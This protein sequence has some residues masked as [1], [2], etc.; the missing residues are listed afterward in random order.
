[1]KATWAVGTLLPRHTRRAKPPSSSSDAHTYFTPSGS[2]GAFCLRLT[3]L[4][5][6]VVVKPTAMAV[7]PVCCRIGR[8]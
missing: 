8:N 6:F 2:V 7:I 5:G 1:M 3:S 4:V